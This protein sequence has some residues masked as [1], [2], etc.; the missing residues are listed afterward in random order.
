VRGAG[1]TVF[2]SGIGVVTQLL[3]TVSLAR[4]LTPADFG[5]VTMVTTFSLL[6]LNFGGN[7]FTEIVLHREEINQFL[8]SNLFWINVGAAVVFTIGF[9]AAGTLM[10][11]FYH[12]PRVIHVALGVSLTI[13]ITSFS[14]LHTALLKRAMLFS[15]VSVNELIAGAISVGL[16]IVLAYLGWGYWALVAGLVA[17]P[18]FQSAGVWYLCRWTPNLPRRE[19][20]TGEALRFAMNVYGR[21]SVNYSA[22][23]MDNLLVGWRFEAAALGFYKKAYDLF[24]L[25][26]AQLVTP[27]S[28]VAVSALSR[29]HR[30]TVQYKRY[31]LGA[32][33]VMAFVGMGIGADLTLVGR[34]VIRLVLGPGWETSGRIFT[35]FGPGIGVMFLYYT[36]G[37]IHLSIGRAD[38]WFRW[39]IMEFIVTGLLFVLAIHWGPVGIAIAWTVSFWILTVPAFWYAGKPIGL[40][41]APVFTAVWKYLLASLM[42]AGASLAIIR[43]FWSFSPAANSW[44]AFV[45]VTAISALFGTL[46]LGAVI[47]LHGGFG[48]LRQVGRLLGEMRPLQRFSKSKPE[49]ILAETPTEALVR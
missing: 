22:R 3:A 16:S 39:G 28:N 4:L 31:L 18:I 29:L 26:A 12:D 42:A 13:F 41:V 36:H 19:P 5:V 33:G 49:S 2:S 7:G 8:A 11:R 9:A 6:L 15:I 37:W 21:F 27:L 45:R 24:A 30:D 43:A 40:G 32:L 14:V 48:P 1:I 44:A 47:L 38:R 46:Y 25:S 20:G 10:A 17:R 34:D 23:N 35:Y